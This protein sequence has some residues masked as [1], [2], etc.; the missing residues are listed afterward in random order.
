MNSVA[1]ELYKEIDPA[2]KDAAWADKSITLLRR[3]WRTIVNVQQNRLNKQILLS[4]ESMS[5]IIDSFKDKGFKKNVEILPLGI[6]ENIRN[7]LTEEII[8]SPPAAEIRATD[9]SAQNM[10]EQDIL[11][12]KNRKIIEKD[13]TKYQTAV[14][15]PPYQVDYVQF[16]GN[17]KDFDDKGLD[18]ND[19]DDV[20]FYKEN[21]QR[22]NFEIASQSVIN[23]VMATN[24]FDQSTISS[25]VDDIL[26]DKVCCMQC[27]V[28]KITGEIKYRYVYPDTA[29]GIFGDSTDGVGDICRGWQDSI[30]VMQFLQMAGNEFDFNKDWKMILWALN[31]YNNWKYTGFLRNGTVYNIAGHPECAMMGL[32]GCDDQWLDWT[33]AYTYKVYCGYIE[34]NT[35]EA[36][37]TYLR[38][39][40]DPNYADTV[41]YAYDLKK[42][43]MTKGFYKESYYQQQWYCSYFIATTSVTQWIFNYSKV[44]YQQLE[45]ANDEYSNGTLKYF[46]ERG[47]SAVQ[48]A[49][50]YIDMA[51]FAFYRMLWAI[52]HAKPKS[53]EYLIE[54]LIQVAKGL[55]RLYPDMNATNGVPAFDNILTQAIQ[56]QEEN[57][58]HIRAFPQV[59]GKTVPQLP[60]T[61][62]E[63]NGIDPVAIA[64]QS[65]VS[66]AESQVAAKI[67]MNPMRFGFNPPSRE[68][69]KS[70][71][72]SVSGSF[73][74]T[75]YIYRMIQY[76]KEQ[77]ATSTT[78]YAQTIM[79]FKDSIPYKWLQTLVGF[80]AFDG[81]ALLEQFAA[82]RVGVFVKDAETQY[83]KQ[84]IMQAATAAL[85]AKMIDYSGWFIVTQTQDYKLGNKILQFL[86]N[87][88]EKKLRNQQ[89][90]DMQMQDQMAQNQFQRQ[91]DLLNAQ[92]KVDLQRAQIMA[93]GPVEAAR[94]QSDGRIQVKQ[95]GIDAE[96]EKQAD[97]A[98]RQKEV[99]QSKENAKSQ[100]SFPVVEEAQ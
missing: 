15:L 88:K 65:V 33:L 29:Y 66:W 21:F 10:R 20:N 19:P 77:I 44:Y 99:A 56:Y 74:S 7:T 24:R 47:R 98:E 9:P 18:E 60:R 12:M 69:F 55:Q 36:T 87:K 96:P 82:H 80:E 23:N 26:A 53:K 83:E 93:S 73:N 4:N 22:L 28:D 100:K 85:Q 63:M 1:I 76:M 2:R 59:E 51:N 75:G 40:G 92:W 72:S 27:Y 62:S 90:Q 84:A 67:G 97:K 37:E 86:T 95:I 11:L 71:Q 52:Y 17:V 31:Y 94:V 70:E 35:V 81:L 64:M 58:V 14:G 25:F 68:S 34:W 32:E 91:M 57:L 16:N 78:M 45:G 46:R 8:K 43:E 41:P 38:R 13:L 49:K 42:K 39:K 50:P 61:D 54:E 48:I 5:K 79:K 6:F 30:T 3:D 89:L